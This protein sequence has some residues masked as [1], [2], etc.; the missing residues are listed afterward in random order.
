[1]EKNEKPSL[2]K[3]VKEIFIGK[4]RN[5]LDRTVFHNISLIAFF[6]WVGLGADG[7]SSSCYGPSE[8]FI[9]LGKHYYL[10]ILVALATAFTIFI[11]AESYSQIIELFPTGGGGYIVASKLLSP[12]IGMVSGCALLIDYVLTIT[13]SIA[14]GADALFSFLPAHFIAYKVWFAVAALLLLIIMN[15]RGIK[16]SVTIL[17]PIFLTFVVSHAI[18]ILYALFAHLSNFSVVAQSTVT[19]V[20]S[21]L[22]EVGFA[23]ML[24]LLMRAYSMGAGTYTGIEAVSNGL[25]ILRE[26]KVKT[27]KNTMKYMVISLAAVVLGLMFSYALYRI[28]PVYGKTINAI[29]FEKVAGG[30][31]LPGYLFI[32]ITLISEAAILFVASQAGFIDGPRV[33]SNMAADRW[34]PK[35][36]ALL[37][38]R[39]VTMN[40]ILIMGISSIV[41]MIATNGS[42]GYLIVLYSIN[43][44]ITFCLSQTGMVKHWW[45][46]RKDVRGW[47][48]KLF[49]NGIGLTLTTFILIMIT[50]IKFHEG[51]W[52]TL[53]ITGTLVILMI[54]IKRS[55]EQ[56]DKMINKLNII[57]DEVESQNPVPQIPTGPGKKY[58]F[59]PN[60]KTAIIIVKDFTGVGL[61]TIFSI[62]RSFGPVFNNF[63]FVQ[64]GLI[65]AGVF[66]GHEEIGKVQNKVEKEVGRYVE[67]MKRS[68]YFAESKCIY[69][70]DTAEEVDKAAKELLLRFPNA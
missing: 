66:R 23:G 39:L 68:G 33:L 57:I 40:G 56:T 28:Q 6:A 22:S 52:I 15:L 50:T 67:L 5:P 12:K 53:F 30:W 35:R 47:F 46:V 51:G 4:A 34:V 59:N 61:R 41:L 42:V 45:E 9:T 65:D 48:G 25:P 16:E 1:M 69:G 8:A 54:I 44:F 63:V 27:A 10:G 3:R 17:T 18:V 20:R 2:F 43:V 7:L 60:D 36:F 19:D 32:L 64:M 70:I 26:P 21:T 29:L 13:L 62:F 14:S 31:G 55:Y 49:I 11:I 24:I 37:S 38:D 58:T